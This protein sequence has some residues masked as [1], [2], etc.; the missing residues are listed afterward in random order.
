MSGRP[1][2]L[3]DALAEIDRLRT[4]VADLQDEVA[5]LERY[6]SFGQIPRLDQLADERD[7]LRA[8][9]ERLRVAFNAWA[10][11]ADSLRNEI[12]P[13]EGDR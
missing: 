5:R 8:E 9:V 2:N 1:D 6:R 11:Y 4:E 13:G 3:K 7:Q 10:D 12:D